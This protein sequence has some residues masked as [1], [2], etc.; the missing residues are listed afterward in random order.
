MD[1]NMKNLT[2]FIWSGYPYFL[3]VVTTAVLWVK[4]N[5]VYKKDLADSIREASVTW[6]EIAEARKQRID[7]L[8][9]E[10]ESLKLRIA[11]CTCQGKAQVTP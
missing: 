8:M 10:N 7:D 11:A 6:H 5:S 9:K 3:A 2:K 4:G 1:E